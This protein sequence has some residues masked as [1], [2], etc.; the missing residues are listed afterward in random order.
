MLKVHKQFSK[1]LANLFW[2]EFVFVKGCTLIK[3]RYKSNHH[4][5]DASFPM[6]SEADIN[7]SNVLV[8]CFQHDAQSKRTPFYKA[9][10][11]DF[12]RAC[13]IGKAICALWA[14]KLMNDFPND[15]FRIYFH[16][17]MPIVRFHMVRKGTENF[18]EAKHFPKE[19]EKGE[20]VILDTRILKK[21]EVAKA[22]RRNF[23]RSWIK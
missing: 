16:G 20:I 23:F 9:R 13:E 19:I 3:D 21:T 2:P 12:L 5:F 17:F 6:Q 18:F 15:N 14:S 10:H 8:E 11:P 1:N 4:L 7:Y 22:N